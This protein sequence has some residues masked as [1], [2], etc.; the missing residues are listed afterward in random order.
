MRIHFIVA[1]WITFSASLS[2]LAFGQ[3]SFA[4]PSIRLQPAQAVAEAATDVN[5]AVEPVAAQAAANEIDDNKADAAK[6]AEDKTLQEILNDKPTPPEPVDEAALAA[7][8][9]AEDAA[10]KQRQAIIAKLQFDRR[11]STALKIWG[12]PLSNEEDGQ[13]DDG[14]QDEGNPETAKDVANENTDSSEASQT[15]DATAARTPAQ[16]L[17]EEMAEHKGIR[18]R[19]SATPKRCHTWELG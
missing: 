11:S 17:A 18:Q 15:Q 7:R 3:A 16:L 10:K 6:Q 14:N 9:T 4:V 2:S 19:D 13:A 12:T 8:K 1:G 5:D